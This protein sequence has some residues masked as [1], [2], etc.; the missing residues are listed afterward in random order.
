[1][2]QLPS[3][4]PA[5][6]E[7][8][9]MIAYLEESVRDLLTSDLELNFGSASS[10]GSHHPSRECFM[11]ETP[12]RHAKSAH[13]VAGLTRDDDDDDEGAEALPDVREEQGTYARPG[14]PWDLKNCRQK[15]RETL[16]EYIRR[17]SRQ[18]NELPDIADT[19][20]IGAFLS[21][22]TCESLVHKL[23]RKGP[24]TTKELLDIATGHASGEEAVGAIF[25][26]SKGKAKRND[27]AGE[28][29]SN[30]PRKKKNK[31]WREGSL[32]A[33]ADRKG[34]RKPAR[35][36]RSLERL[37]EGPCPN[38]AYTVKHAYKD[39]GLMKKFLS[40]GSKKG[41][42]K[43]KPVPLEDDVDEKQDAFPEETGCLMIFGGPTVY[44]SKRQQKLTRCEVYAAEPA[45]P[46]FLWWLRSPITFDRSN[47]PDSVM[48]PG[49]YPLI[50][51]PIIDK[52][53]LSKVLMDG[54]SG[55]NIMNVE[56]LDAMGIDRS[57][58]RPTG[59]PFHSVVPWKQARPLGQIDLPMTFGDKS[60]FGTETLTFEVV[61]FHK[62][63]H[64]IL[65]RPCYVKFM[66]V[67]NYTYLKL[68]M[69][70][71]HGVITIGTFF[72]RTYECD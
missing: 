65:G 4:L 25:D 28:G 10:E 69:P 38:H 17:F 64:A 29:A 30:R 56:M 49:R 32:V 61:S 26:R 43:K 62:T 34:G 19:D 72:Q 15:S 44:D 40:G 63:Y 13:E 48:H 57:R 16:R 24:R 55:L 53:H 7:F 8:V 22:T 33:A 51:D 46:A 50:V 2:A 3:S 58:I 21:G 5:N 54:G 9:G 67:P 27:D 20:V 12:E 41:D 68:K 35:A 59:A 14:N 45:T 6:D 42:G 37:L 52:K 23:G 47:Y 66:A 60:N 71:P 36:P 18:C 31:Q 1:M 70:S 39:C 11:A